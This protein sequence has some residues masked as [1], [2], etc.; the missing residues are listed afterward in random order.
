MK[1]K[2]LGITFLS[3]ITLVGC[4]AG[5][6]DEVMDDDFGLEPTRFDNTVN[7]DDRFNDQDD[8]RN[9][10]NNNDW[11]NED[12]YR[13]R[14][15]NNNFANMGNQRNG[16]D[17]YEVSERAADQI[18]EDI[19][20]VERAYVL[21]LGDNAYVAVTL[22]DNARNNGMNNNDLNNNRNGMNDNAINNNRNGMNNNGI[23]NNRNG[24]NRNGND[25]DANIEEEITRIV[26]TQNNNIDN[27]YVS[28]NAD[29]VDLTNDYANDVDNGEPVEGFFDEFGEMV[30]RIFPDVQ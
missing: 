10:R 21:T 9:F 11:T 12:T 27:V 26:R 30:D 22:R 25:I 6:N 18:A 15:N 20:K 3:A 5:N 14:D 29:F 16:E 4:N 2:L 17:N 28:T 1:V 13:D 19:N 8:N 23:N 24:I 7:V